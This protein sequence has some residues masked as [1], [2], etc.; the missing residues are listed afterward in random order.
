[1]PP[2]LVSLISDVVLLI[3][4]AAL[5]WIDL[6]QFR[7][8]DALTLPLVLLGLGL[9]LTG[10]GPAPLDAAIGA[11][12]GFAV[13]WALGATYFRLRKIDGLGLGDAKLMAAAGAWLGWQML[14]WLVLG[15]SLPALVFALVAG[16]GHH[17]RIAFGL[18]L[19]LS[20]AVLRLAT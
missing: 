17:D 8:P 12:A 10:H 14:P 4:L 18:C 15:A 13:F 3:C 6:R 5:A 19:C 11:A 2:V 20:F 7:L 1:M 16:Q 9:S